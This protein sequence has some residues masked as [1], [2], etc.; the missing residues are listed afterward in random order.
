VN[1]CGEIDS[2]D[3]VAPA[4]EITKDHDID[5]LEKSFTIWIS[6]LVEWVGHLGR[7]ST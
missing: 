6:E 2:A 7:L 1:I 4:A 5:M 3:S